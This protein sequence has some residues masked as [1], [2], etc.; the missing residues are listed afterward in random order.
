M[1]KKLTECPDPS[2]YCLFRSH[3][4]TSAFVIG[5]L[6]RLEPFST[7]HIC[8]QGG[9]YDIGE[10]LL[11]S[12]PKAWTSI[13]N[14]QQNDFRELIPGFFFDETFFIS[15]NGFDLGYFISGP[16]GER[17]KKIN[18]VELPK[19]SKSPRDF[20]N[21][22]RKALKADYVSSHLHNWINLIFG[23]HRRSI[24]HDNLFH[25]Y[26]YPDSI[27][28][29]SFDLSVIQGYASNFGIFPACLFF[30]VTS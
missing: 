12:I 19:W 7:L 15:S 24:D 29:N 30:L 20:I 9:S 6:I 23:V 13:T 26:T 10:R 16:N 21:I 11:Y 5:Y 22:H 18:D 17:E 4:S 27:N 8:L 2:Q 14:D 28:H 3:F 1:K 25:P